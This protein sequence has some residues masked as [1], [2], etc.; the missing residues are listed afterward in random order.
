[1]IFFNVETF[2]LT[3]GLPWEGGKKRLD[4]TLGDWAE[5]RGGAECFVDCSS[6][7]QYF[8]GV[9]VQSPRLNLT[10]GSGAGRGDGAS[11]VPWLAG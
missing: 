8:P 6:I 4:T 2:L 10:V 9:S 7:Y 3:R 11:W 5:L 1:M